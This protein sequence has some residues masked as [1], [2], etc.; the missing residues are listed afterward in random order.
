MNRPA[1]DVVILDGVRTAFT[2]AQKGSLRDTR[3]DTLAAHVIREAVARAGVEPPAIEDVV[4]GCA[5]PE[6][7]QG[8]NVAR[9][10]AALAGLPDEVPAMTINR[11]CSSG[12]QSIAIVGDRIAAGAMDCAVAG[13][14]ES[15]SM[16]PMTG[17]K[18]SLNPELVE[19]RPGL[20][21]PMGVTAENVARRFGVSRADQ[22]A[23]AY[24]SHQRAVAA[25][26]AGRFEAEIL[27]ITSTL[28]EGISARPVTAAR[29]EFPRGDTTVE[30]L[31]AL[32]PVFDPT[33]SVTAG[34]SSPLTDGAAAVV[35]TSGERAAALGRR[36]LGYLRH[37]AVAGVDPTIMGTGP[38]P[39]VRKV[40][41]KAGMSVGEIDLFEL[42]EAF[43]AQVLYSV[44][45]LG[46]D[47]EKVNVNGG[48][49]ALGHP[50]G[51]S[52]T[53]L[54]LTILH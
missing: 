53:R 4:L 27:P 6:A 20:Y 9:M 35:V 31:A 22:D 28:L 7:E 51:V 32:R 1:R 42:N 26:A 40:L 46:L 18:P 14:V 3:P 37:F 12:L 48:A 15:M 19:K 30:K 33:G 54:A 50:L 41:A 25:I 45:E 38:V 36:P 24:R 23:F 34:N 5:M 29:D 39:A 11:F 2:R 16:I 43:A 8:L 17:T 49:I 10:A 21:T 52:G 47:E 44:R 13:G